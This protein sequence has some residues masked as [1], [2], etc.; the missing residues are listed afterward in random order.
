MCHQCTNLLSQ[1]L[2]TSRRGVWQENGE[3]FAPD[4]RREIAS[5]DAGPQDMRDSMQHLIPQ[6]VPVLVVNRFE[7]IDVDHHHGSA[8]ESPVLE[9]RLARR[10][11]EAPPI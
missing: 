6:Q 9:Q 7:M 3:L 11:F 5:F 4:A 2:R 1:A 8:R 10:L